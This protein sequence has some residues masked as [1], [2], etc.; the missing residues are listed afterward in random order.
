MTLDQQLVRKVTSEMSNINVIEREEEAITDIKFRE[1]LQIQNE[2]LQETIEFIKKDLITVLRDKE[3]EKNTLRECK[4]VGE[5]LKQ[6]L[7]KLEEATDVNSIESARAELLALKKKY[8]VD[9]K[10]MSD[11]LDAHYPVHPVDGAGPL[12]DEC[13]LKIIVE[14]SDNI[15]IT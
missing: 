15:S 8:E 13:E 3:K 4:K 10:D 5:D 11:F 2:Q 1:K 12:G 14:V 7:E 9:I 6:R